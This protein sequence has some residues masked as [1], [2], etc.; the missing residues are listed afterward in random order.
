MD[1]AIDSSV[2]NKLVNMTLDAKEKDLFDYL[3]VNKDIFSPNEKVY[4][5]SVALEDLTSP[6]G[7]LE[8]GIKNFI[9][10]EDVVKDNLV[11]I[12]E[13]VKK[14]EEVEYTPANE[15]D[16]YLLHLL[17]MSCAFGWTVGYNIAVQKIRETFKL[18]EG[19]CL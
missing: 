3:V 2:F 17:Y 8:N 11:L 1:K 18:Q 4:S 13:P 6:W 14:G 15:T 12:K 16:R 9:L 19:L 5:K 7:K 10:Y